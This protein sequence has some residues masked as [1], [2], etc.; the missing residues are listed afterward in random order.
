MCIRDSPNTDAALW[1]GIAY[2]WIDEGTYDKDYVATHTD[3]FDWFERYVMGGEDGVPKT[4]KWA[5]SK[6]CLLYTSRCV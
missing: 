3:G 1:L 6:C 4:P 2:T 5:E